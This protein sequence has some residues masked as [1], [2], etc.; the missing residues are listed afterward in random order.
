MK[1]KCPYNPL[2]PARMPSQIAELKVDSRGYPI[3]WFVRYVDGEP[4]FQVVDP[5]RI[6]AAVKHKVCWVCGKPLNV[7]LAFAIGPMC[8]INRISGE[9]PQHRECSEFSAVACPFLINPKKERPNVRPPEAKDPGPTMILRNPGVVLVWTTLSYKIIKD[10]AG[11]WLFD[12]GEPIATSWYAEGRAATRHE[13]LEAFMSG[14]PILAEVAAKEYGATAE[15]EKQ[16]KVAWDYIPGEAKAG[17]PCP[18]SM[19]EN[20]A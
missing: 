13:V 6:V 12:L 19:K 8:A 5:N 9:P 15:L 7:N 11:R 18:V 10:P 17:E 20:S 2:I 14:Y 4:D 3:P 1:K 16:L